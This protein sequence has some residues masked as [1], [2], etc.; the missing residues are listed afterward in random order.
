[1]VLGA[2]PRAPLVPVLVVVLVPLL[3]QAE[4][5]IAATSPHRPSNAERLF[6]EWPSQIT[7]AV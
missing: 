6:I 5:R 4:S 1:M 3:P 7:T 2:V